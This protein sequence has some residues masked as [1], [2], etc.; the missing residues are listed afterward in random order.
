MA[1]LL[2]LD[3]LEISNFRAFRHLRIERLGRVNLIVGKNNTGKTSLLEALWLYEYQASPWIIWQI[4]EARDEGRRPL[5]RAGRDPL[6]G[7]DQEEN[8][9]LTIKHLFYGRKEVGKDLEPIKIGSIYSP[10]KTL[11]AI[12]RW[13]TIEVYEEIG[14]ELEPLRLE[15]YN[16]ADNPVPG[17]AIK[18]GGLSEIFYRLDVTPFFPLS[19]K[20]IPCI[21]IPANGLHMMDIGR[22]WDSIALTNL[23]EDVLDSMRIIAPYV[24]RVNLISPPHSPKERVPFVKIAGYD[25]PIPL[26]SLGEGMNRLFSI[27]LAL[28]NAKGKMLLIDEVESGLHYS[29]QPDVWRLIFEAAHRLNVQVFATTHSWDCIEAFQQAA[30]ENEQEEGVLIRLVN[31]NGEIVADLFDEKELG[32]AAREE[33]EIR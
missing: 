23:E 25:E 16:T 8:R 22:L 29:A 9:I 12:V 27:A 6:D 15:E 1:E 30:Q 20:G 17:L 19:L 21:F 31:K 10:E 13:Y 7:E 28:V 18:I 26:R 11:S 24:E 5:S 14:R 33:I 32:I 2:I 3:S 4:L